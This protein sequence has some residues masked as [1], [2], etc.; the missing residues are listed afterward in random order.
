MFISKSM[1]NEQTTGQILEIVDVQLYDT[2]HCP[3][4]EEEK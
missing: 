3:R 4:A 2:Y 1:W